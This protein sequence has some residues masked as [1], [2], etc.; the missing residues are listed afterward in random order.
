MSHRKL[1]SLP[2]CGK[3]WT[4]ACAVRVDP[5]WDDSDNL[6]EIARG[7]IQGS[8]RGSRTA[9]CNRISV[10]ALRYIATARRITFRGTEGSCHESCARISPSC[11][12]KLEFL[13]LVGT[14]ASWLAWRPVWGGLCYNEEFAKALDELQFDTDHKQPVLFEMLLQGELGRNNAGRRAAR[15]SSS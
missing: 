11:S 6:V 2:V 14:L 15:A 12:R 13:G 1:R 4:F 5:P 7:K 8:G 9:R 3:A 10:S